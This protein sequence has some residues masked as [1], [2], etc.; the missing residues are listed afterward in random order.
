MRRIRCIQ[1]TSDR[2]KRLPAVSHAISC[3]LCG[4]P[5]YPHN[6]RSMLLFVF[7]YYHFIWHR[8]RNSYQRVPF[9]IYWIQSKATKRSP[10]R[11][12]N[13][14]HSTFIKIADESK[15][16]LQMSYSNQR[17]ESVYAEHKRTSVGK[18][19]LPIGCNQPE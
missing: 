6:P 3:T 10:C 13:E 11:K 7:H 1:S 5:P 8:A 4:A 9:I 16:A 2:F 12:R 18:N 17:A 14:N 15:V 19:H